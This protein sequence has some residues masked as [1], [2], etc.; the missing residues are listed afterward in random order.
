M[1]RQLRLSMEEFE[2]LLRDADKLGAGETVSH[3]H[4]EPG[5]LVVIIVQ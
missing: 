2:H 3:V 5:E 4:I 1:E